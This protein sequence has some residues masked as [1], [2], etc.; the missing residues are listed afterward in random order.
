MNKRSEKEEFDN[1]LNEL[2][3]DSKKLIDIEPA[4]LYKG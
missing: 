1:F 4:F 3:D 2:S